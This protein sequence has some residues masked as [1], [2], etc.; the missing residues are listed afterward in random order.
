MLYYLGIAAGW[1]LIVG[2]SAKMFYEFNKS[3]MIRK[4]KFK[5]I[6]KRIRLDER[7]KV[8]QECQLKTK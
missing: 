5:D 2:A 3:V 8:M 6:E 1:S 7:E 4:D